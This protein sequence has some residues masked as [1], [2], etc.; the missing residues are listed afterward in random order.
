VRS[1]HGYAYV[2]GVS[3]LTA[4]SLG[5]DPDACKRRIADLITHNLSPD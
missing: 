3:L 5:D 4:E 1:T 2:F